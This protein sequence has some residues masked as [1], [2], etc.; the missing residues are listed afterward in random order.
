MDGGELLSDSSGF[1]VWLGGGAVNTGAVGRVDGGGHRICSPLSLAVTFLTTGS[2]NQMFV[3]KGMSLG[4]VKKSVFV[5]WFCRL[6][7]GK[8]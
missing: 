7:E 6:V 5:N 4:Q 1:L 2:M 3:Y 8:K